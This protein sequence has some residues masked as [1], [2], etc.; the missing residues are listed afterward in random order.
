MEIME[1]E[2]IQNFKE[3]SDFDADVTIGKEDKIITLS[4]CAYEYD[5]ARYVVMGI[6]QEI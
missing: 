2:T 6:L 4:T 5:G 1:P 3:K